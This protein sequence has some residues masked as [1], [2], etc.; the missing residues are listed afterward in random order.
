MSYQNIGLVPVLTTSAGSCL[1]QENWQQAEVCA[2]SFHL[3][4]LLMKPGFE[5]LKNL[6]D[7][8]TYLGWQNL[9]VLNASSLSMAKDGRYMLRSHYDGVRSHYTVQDIIALITTLKPNVVVLPQ[10]LAHYWL[11][12]PETIFPFI[13][14]VEL[15]NHSEWSRSYGVHFTHDSAV[16]SPAQLLERLDTCKNV[17]CYVTGDIDVPL[18]AELVARGV[19]FVESDTP[20]NH[21]LVGNVYNSS[22]GLIS[23]LASETAMCFDVIDQHCQCPVCSQKFTQAYLHHL[24]EHTPLLCQRYLIQHNVYYCQT[25]LKKS[26]NHTN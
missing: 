17:P 8:A 26:F 24:F 1:T 4:A 18:M 15:S 23:L 3:S 13:P 10:G 5:C 21:G 22:G 9:L 12:L 14:Y 6:P 11:S 16:S 2:A 20:A 7:L 19:S 25:T